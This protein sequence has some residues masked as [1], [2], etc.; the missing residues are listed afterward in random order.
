MSYHHLVRFGALVVFVATCPPGSFAQSEQVAKAEMTTWTG[1]L[2]A[3]GAK[4]RLEVDIT[5]DGEQL[6]GSLRSLDQ[7]DANI[8]ASDIQVD[9]EL[10][11]SVPQIGAK[12]VGKY[13]DDK[14][15]A[16]GTFTQGPASLP[17]TLT[18]SG[19]KTTA[20]PKREKLKEA[21][22]GKLNLGLMNPVMQFRIVTKES[23]ET[24]AYFDSVTEGRTGFDAVWSIDEGTLKFDVPK[25][26]LSFEGKL[27]QA[28]DTA[29]GTWK[30]GGREVPLTVKKQATEYD[31]VNAWENRPQRPVAPFPYDALE[32]KFENKDDEL[33]L[34]GTLT[35]PRKPGR[36]PAVVLITGSGA[37]D[38][39]ES[40]MQHKPFL[41]LAD[42]LSRRG[43]A[44]LR[45]DD[46]G[47]AQ[48]T[49]KFMGATT[50]AFARDAAAAV[51][52]L[53]HHSRINPDEIGLAGHSEGGLV[54]P[55]VVGLRDDVAFV[56]LLAATGVDG[57]TI[58]YSQSEAMTRAA[59]IEEEE[60]QIALKLN[61]AMIR[62]IIESPE[63]NDVLKKN[64]EKAIDDVIATIPE[65]DREE[66]SKNV[67]A[68]IRG[69]LPTLT[70]K[71]MRFF[72]AYDPRPALKKM[73]CPTLA[74]IGTKD[75][76]VLSD[77]NTPEIRKALTEGGNTDFE[78][79]VL[80]GLNH[81]FQ[82]CETG[83]LSEYLTIQET[84]SPKALKI[85]GDWIVERTTQL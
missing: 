75:T 68:T 35:I 69:Q 70:G 44:V 29:E 31:D 42:D 58:V 45:Y 54:A 84:F 24:A 11:F 38:R 59:G 22:V 25:I 21:W 80:D 76:Q 46:R 52:F 39:D 62:T 73:K 41:V 66:A 67:R 83:A 9:G 3:G 74:I 49:G 81:L 1:T 33:T 65:A 50:E 20:P 15:V 51:E 48:S 5:V 78:I 19:T 34:A 71:W 79:V 30:Q 2:N 23:G 61:R 37:Q 14:T 53:K 85:I 4:L 27:N 64:I 12:F 32:V 18:K 57:E 77:L 7:G 17:L 82:T 43:I 6:T 56:V 72:L 36:H 13:S 10:S 47:T 55:M 26:K 8:K 40:L 28:G 16:E 60:I 63:D